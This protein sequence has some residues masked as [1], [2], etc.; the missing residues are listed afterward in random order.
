[1]GA[2]AQALVRML[3]PAQIYKPLIIFLP[4]LFHGHGALRLHLRILLPAACAWFLASAVVYILND[5]LDLPADRLTPERA[6]RPLVTGAVRIP[7]ALLLAA[8]LAA[9]LVP[10]LRALP[11]RETT[12]IL[13]YAAVNL[14][15][16]LGL[17]KLLAAR[18][19]SIALGFW[20]RLQGGATPV[21]PIPLTPWASLF[22]LGL[23]YFLNCLKGMGSY[24]KEI[25]RAYR[26]AMAMGAGLA[27]SLALA[28]LVAICLKRGVEGSMTF[29][30]MPP[31]LCLVGMHRTAFACFQGRHQA[32]QASTFF[33]DPVTL[34]AMLGF[35]A[36]FV[37]A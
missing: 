26:F 3:R 31:L 5:I 6:H 8:A 19:A 23:A 4:A 20:L 37:Y 33:L 16:A 9:V 25:H 10:L 27:G 12:L 21:A 14:A 32:E 30:E 34:L 2:K 15:Y 36:F 1:M 22:T 11:G 13:C 17:K 29:P 35:V 18:Q 24:D 7:E 28:S